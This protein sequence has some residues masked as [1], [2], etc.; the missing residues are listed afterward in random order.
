MFRGAYTAL[1]T[2]LADDRVDEPALARLAQHQLDA[3]IDGLVPCGTTGESATLSISE[4]VRAIEVVMRT[5]NGRVPV[6]AGAGSNCTRSAIETTRACKELGTAATLHVTPYYNK[7][8]Q[9]ELRR[10]FLTIAD[11]VGHPIVLYNVPSRTCVDLLPSTVAALA[12]HP[13]IVGIKD[14]TG[15]MHRVA[16]LRE[17]C[18]DDFALLSGDDFSLLGFLATGGDGVVS[19]CSNVVPGVFVELC[20]AVRDGDLARARA[21]Q[22]R[23][24]PLTRCLFTKSNPIPLKAA[25]SAMGLCQNKLYPPMFPLDLES[26]EGQRL[27]AALREIGAMS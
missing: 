23:H 21:L 17:R 12:Q 14:A 4:H 10:H 24:L 15:D 3:G 1:A 6:I 11:R 22:F 2:P 25:L 5:A 19:V 7:P 8:G 18:G 13:M 20:Q 27:L 9:D 16:E 26:E